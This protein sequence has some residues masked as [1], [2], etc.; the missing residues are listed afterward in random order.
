MAWSQDGR[1][2]ACGGIRG[3]FYQCDSKGTVLEHK[4]GVRVVAMAF[5]KDSK[6]ILAADTHHRI[7]AYN[8]DEDQTDYTVLQESRLENHGIISFTLDDSDR[9]ALLNIANQVS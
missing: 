1:K 5:R 4:E 2:I 9:Y 6:F 7:R 8:L 3:Q